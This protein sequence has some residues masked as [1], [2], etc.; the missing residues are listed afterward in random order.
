MGIFGPK[1]ILRLQAAY[2][3]AG[4]FQVQIEDLNGKYAHLVPFSCISLVE[5]QL[6]VLDSYHP[7]S[8]SSALLQFALKPSA[9]PKGAIHVSGFALE[10]Y[11]DRGHVLKNQFFPEYG[12]DV[13]QIGNHELQL[14]IE[15]IITDYV[16]AIYFS[17]NASEQANIRLFLY[18]AIDFYRQKLAAIARATPFYDT[19]GRVEIANAVIGF[20]TSLYGKWDEAKP[21]M[22]ADAEFTQRVNG[23][24]ELKSF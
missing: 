7:I 18:F 17:Q 23:L 19:A 8:L 16:S 3:P 21:F 11:E 2:A 13:A 22:P 24:L 12:P 6:T 1:R 20:T 9:Q 10:L 4:K 14:D 5:S 15:H